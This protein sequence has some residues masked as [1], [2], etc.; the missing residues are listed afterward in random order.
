MNKALNDE[1]KRI[2]ENLCFENQDKPDGLV[3]LKMEKRKEKISELIDRLP[4]VEIIDID[5]IKI[6]EIARYEEL[7][8]NEVRAV[9]NV[10]KEALK[11]DE[12]IEYKIQVLQAA[13][14]KQHIYR[15]PDLQSQYDSLCGYLLIKYARKVTEK[16]NGFIWAQVTG[17]K[18]IAIMDPFNSS[19]GVMIVQLVCLARY[20]QLESIRR[21]LINIVR[22]I[23]I[24]TEIEIER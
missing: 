5:I 19:E 6:D 2:L 24:K 16:K 9:S 17:Q 3:D 18:D 23:R 10:Q 4:D 11:E 1:L 20:Y 8:S 7:L 22:S 13:A 14:Q 12:E 15:Y 21:E